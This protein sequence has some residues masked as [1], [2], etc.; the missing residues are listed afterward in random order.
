MQE[1]KHVVLK[2][3]KKITNAVWLDNDEKVRLLEDG[4]FFAWPF[5]YGTS[6]Y[7][8]IAKFDLE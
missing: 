3:D 8:R 7:L 1:T 4:T 2:T 6:Y 5:D